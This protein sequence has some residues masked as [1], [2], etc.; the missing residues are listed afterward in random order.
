MRASIRKS[1]LTLLQKMVSFCSPS[2]LE[3]VV[4][5][6]ASEYETEESLRE[7]SP[8]KAFPPS[9]QRSPAR[10]MNQHLYKEFG[11]LLVDFLGILLPADQEN[12]LLMLGLKIVKDVMRMRPDDFYRILLRE[13]IVSHVEALA[14]SAE[15][16]NGKAHDLGVMAK[17]IVEN[18]FAKHT[19]TPVGV[20]GELRGLSNR[21][22]QLFIP[23]LNGI[24]PA[25]SEIVSLLHDLRRYLQDEKTV[26]PFE[27]ENAGVME[28]LIVLL[29][30]RP[31]EEDASA[32]EDPLVTR[33][34][35]FLSS[36]QDSGN[37]HDGGS[38]PLVNLLR[39]LQAILASIERLPV[40]SNTTGGLAGGLDAL[41]KPMKVQLRLAP[42]EQGLVDLTGKVIKMEPLVTIGMLQ[43]FL[44]RKVEPQWHNRDRKDLKFV[45]NLLALAS[46]LQLNHES[47]FDVHGLLYY[48]GSN[49]RTK[50]WVNPAKHG[51]VS[52]TSSDGRSLPY[53]KLEDIAS[54]QSEPRNCHTK[55]RPN[56]WF[57][58]DLGVY[59]IPSA[60]TL[61]HSRGYGKSALR[62]WQLEMSKDGNAWEVLLAHQ[63]DES[64]IEPGS[65]CTWKIQAPKDTQGWR[66]MRILQTGR[67]GTSK[68]YLS[69]SGFEIY[70][71]VVT[72]TT[73]RPGR[74]IMEMEAAARQHARRQVHKIVVGSRVIRG[75]DWKW[76]NQD[77]G[78]GGC[79]TVQ[80]EISEGWLDV[81]WDHGESNR[82]RMGAQ[83]SYDLK[84][85]D[86][87]APTPVESEG[88][89]D[90]DAE[91]IHES[92]QCDGCEMFPIVGNRYKCTVCKDY[93]VCEDCYLDDVHAEEGH[94]F[95]VIERP[96][97][98][99][100]M[101]PAR[102]TPQRDS[103]ATPERLPKWDEQAVLKREFSSLEAAFDPRRSRT[104]REQ[105]LTLRV[106]EPGQPTESQACDN[107]LPHN[108]AQHGGT[109]T[110][111]LLFISLPSNMSSDRI[112]SD[113][114][115]I[116]RAQLLDT[117]TTIFKAA[118]QRFIS[119]ASTRSLPAENGYKLWDP[120]YTITYRRTKPSDAD[121]GPTPWTPVFVDENIGSTELPKLQVIICM[122]ERASPDW[123]KT[124]KLYGET[125]RVAKSFNCQRV[126]A[127]YR[128]FCGE[129]PQKLKGSARRAVYRAKA[130]K[131]Q[132]M[133]NKPRTHAMSQ[134]PGG[135]SH[136]QLEN[137][138][139]TMNLQSKVRRIL[140]IIKIIDQGLADKVHA[141]TSSS[142]VGRKLCLEQQEEELSVIQEL[143]CDKLT[144]KLRQQL[145]DPLAITSGA[146]PDWCQDLVTN[147]APLFPFDVRWQYFTSCSFGVDR[148]VAG[149][150]SAQDRSPERVSFA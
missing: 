2:V 143:I 111:L 43:E 70:G 35:L 18:Y 97:G 108:E 127:A 110:K 79:G 116:D 58:I 125:R 123:L 49:G 57:A 5:R 85:E 145:S 90:D 27:L 74:L 65:T 47:D 75:H 103:E 52:V 73:D 104:G 48:I 34:Q 60:Y 129:T 136:S 56:S 54:R 77:G 42:G 46:P 67:N 39:K 132:E 135:D 100:R 64:L 29:M 23:G 114:A 124:W 95:F 147:Y 144:N 117:D 71:S 4:N 31:S 10:L 86:D 41:K 83:S 68:N 148:A 14:R 66:H 45:Q 96:G 149:I 122:Q 78:L 126:C 13:G 12:R 28:A 141:P 119:S 146:I 37:N 15:Q 32:L 7:L 107:H 120:V 3:R 19:S 142:S 137:F 139:S 11:K 22:V 82:Y 138:L 113:A 109:G 50:E 76:E 17:D 72:A 62:N 98:S 51:L 92:V 88:E 121:G 26:S 20:V 94:T 131:E 89:D 93:D 59:I 130:A 40:H 134:S 140:Q 16:N 81:R 99:R 87:S 1:S 36:M 61:R 6:T 91:A 24:V 101:V 102:M 118:Q 115:Q 30:H 25:D 150:Q 106:A 128:A 21:L 105:P 69:L 133:L 53:G 55:D 44:M 8:M 80:G 9:P 33:R 112:S 38:T 63:N 84:L